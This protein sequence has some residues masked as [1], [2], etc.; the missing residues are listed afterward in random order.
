MNPPEKNVV[1]WHHA[2]LHV[3]VPGAVYMVT[4]GTLHKE[5]GCDRLNEPDEFKPVWP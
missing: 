1:R 4:A 2:P 5:L 3:F